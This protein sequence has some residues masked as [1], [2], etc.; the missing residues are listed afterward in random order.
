MGNCVTMSNSNSNKIKALPIDS[1]FNF[2]SPLPSWPP[3]G[4][5][6]TGTIDL[7]GLIASEVTTFTPVW[8][9]YEGGPE[10][11]G[12]TFFEPTGLPEGY[13]I[14]GYYAQPN[15]RALFGRVVV[16][17]DNDGSSPALKNP[18][19]YALVWSSKNVNIKQD[20][21]GYIW[22]PIPLDG[23]QAVGLVVTTTPEKPALDKVMCVRS[24]LTSACEPDELIWG[25]SKGAG[26]DE[27]NI[28]E[29]R[30]VERGTQAT[31]VSTGTFTAQS[32]GETTTKMPV[33]VC[34]KNILSSYSNMPNLDQVKTV[35]NSYSPRIYNHP[36]DTY[37]PSSVEWFFT[38]GALLYNKGQESNPTPIDP[39]GSNL[40]QGGSNDGLYWLDLPKDNNERERVMKGD[41]TSAYA[42]FHIKPMLG[43]TYTDVAIWLF[44]PFNGGS[45]AKVGLVNIPLGKIGEH[46]GDWEH[47]TLRISNFNGFLWKV[48]FAQHAKGEWVHASNLEFLDSS[49][50]FVGYA[51]LHGHATY[52]HPGDVL[53]GTEFVGIRNDTAKSDKML[54]TAKD[55]KIISADYIRSI[56][57]PPWLNYAREWGPTIAYNVDDEIKK[58]SGL[59][60]GVIRKKFVKFTKSL[61][62]ELF[63]EEGPT[64]PKMKRSWDGDE[65]N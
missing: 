14:L 42:Y 20:N 29:S 64:G 54:D 32:G 47:V 1:K 28:F 16:A 44:Y 61:P 12:A 13:H 38:N 39:T 41:I 48:F 62:S 6:A 51:S 56:I 40:P 53:Q 46:V 19:D 23:Y 63:G 52:A 26:S 21:V 3:G 36:K 2:P 65:I 55:Y 37:L 43:G 8:A 33:L 4:G 49:N 27:F 15:N 59:L 25:R 35:I 24:D 50:S 17:K 34:L 5:F 9:T 30:P 7:G 58:A 11:K 57:E 18:Q 60:P 22:A 10:N 31:A 45:T